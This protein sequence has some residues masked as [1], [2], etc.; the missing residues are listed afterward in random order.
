MT[1]ERMLTEPDP[2]G[3]PIGRVL[4]EAG[5]AAFKD[6]DHG[7]V[8]R[9]MGCNGVRVTERAELRPALAAALMAR[10]RRWSMCA[11]RWT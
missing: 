8:A 4:H 2:I 10:L 5:I 3:E 1:I 7:A 6:F 9:A 11:C